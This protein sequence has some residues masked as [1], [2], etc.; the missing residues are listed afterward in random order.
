MAE[1]GGD[2]FPGVAIE[3]GGVAIGRQPVTGG[4][5]PAG[6]VYQKPASV[7]HTPRFNK[8]LVGEFIDEGEHLAAAYGTKSSVD[9]GAVKTA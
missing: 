1:L 7:F 2:L 9:V 8:H 3:G 5:G 6:G 4:A